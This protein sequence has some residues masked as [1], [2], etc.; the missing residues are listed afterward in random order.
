MAFLH[1][2]HPLA[3]MTETGSLTYYHAFFDE[4]RRLGYRAGRNSRT[5]L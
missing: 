1:P 2:S 5:E 3:D 4:L